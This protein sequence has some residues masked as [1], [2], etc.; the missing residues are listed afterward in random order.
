MGAGN[1]VAVAQLVVELIR[2]PGLMAPSHKWSCHL[3]WLK[4]VVRVSRLLW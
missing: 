1:G 4:G 2:E 3:P